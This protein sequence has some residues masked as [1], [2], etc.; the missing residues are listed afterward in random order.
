MIFNLR[1]DFDKQ[2]FKDY[3][4]KLYSEGCAVELTKKRLNRTL[5][6]NSYLHLVLGW[7][8]CEYGCSLEEV[9]VDY[10]KRICNKELFER[11]KVN[12]HGKT[13]TYLRSSKDLDTSE[14]ALSITRFRDW[15]SAVAGIYL[16]SASERDFLLYVEQEIELNKE[17]I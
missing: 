2:K 13:V 4:N 8:A 9:K 1:S 17:F 12:K 5:S 14:M 10:Y 15:S 7:F 3:C 16:P 11:T 6:Q